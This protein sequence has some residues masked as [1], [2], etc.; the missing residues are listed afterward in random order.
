VKIGLFFGS[1]NPIHIGHLALAEYIY[2][3]S[4]L[5]KLW[6]I[7]SP[8]NPLKKKKTLLED[9]HRLEMVYRSIKDDLRFEVNDIEF[10]MPK[11]SYTIDTISYL[12]EKHPQK[13]FVLIMGADNL[14]SF[15]KWKN[16]ELLEQ[17]IERLVYPRHGFEKE[18]F[19]NQKNLTFIDAPKIE[20]SSSFIRDAIKSGKSVQYFLHPEV[21]RYIDEM[22][23][24]KVG[25]D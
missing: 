21:F 5:D 2:E 18:D 16:A 6:F 8:H 24:Y 3:F 14:K 17:S 23:L 22:N 1:F 13:E 7:V 15:Y 11:P 25:G 9:H 12:K 4:D 19:I 20:I 10:K